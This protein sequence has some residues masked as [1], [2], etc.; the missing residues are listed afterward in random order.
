MDNILMR[1]DKHNAGRLEGMLKEDPLLNGVM[2]GG[3]EIYQTLLSV[4]DTAESVFEKYGPDAAAEYVFN[5]LLES[6]FA[7]KHESVSSAIESNEKYIKG[8]V[9]AAYAGTTIFMAY[10]TAKAAAEQMHSHGADAGASHAP[11]HAQDSLGAGNILDFFLPSAAGMPSNEFIEPYGKVFNATVGSSVS[12][13]ITNATTHE[14]VLNYTSVPVTEDGGFV[15]YNTRIFHGDNPWTSEIENVQPGDDLW[16]FIN[17]T[18]AQLNATK[19]DHWNVSFSDPVMQIDIDYVPPAPKDTTPP[20]IEQ[21]IYH[22]IANGTGVKNRIIVN[23]ATDE[24]TNV[25]V[26]RGG[27]VVH[28]NA[29]YSLEKMFELAANNG[30]NNFSIIAKD[31]SANAAMRWLNVSLDLDPA[32]LSDFSAA[33]FANDADGRK[34]DIGV[35]ANRSKPA[36]YDIYVNGTKAVSN[37]TLSKDAIYEI[38]ANASEGKNDIM[39]EAVT[40]SGV[41][42]S[43]SGT[44]S[45]DTIAPYVLDK[46]VNLLDKDEVS[47]MINVSEPSNWTIRRDGIKIGSNKTKNIGNLFQIIYTDAI[48]SGAGTYGYALDLNDGRNVNDSISLGTITIK[49][50]DKDNG[51]GGGGNNENKGSSSGGGGGGGGGSGEEYANIFNTISG[52]DKEWYLNGTITYL[53]NGSDI[54]NGSAIKKLTIYSKEGRGE[55]SARLQA[56]KH[57]SSMIPA[58]IYRELAEDIGHGGGTIISNLNLV[59]G[60]N[61]DLNDKRVRGAEIEL[62]WDNR[63]TEPIVYAYQPAENRLTKLEVTDNGGKLIAKLPVWKNTTKVTNI[64]IGESPARST[65]LPQEI[66]VPRATDGATPP[67]ADEAKSPKAAAI[68]EIEALAAAGSL[69]AAYAYRRRK[70]LGQK[71]RR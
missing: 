38:L 25:S 15:W 3:T 5:R 43:V 56:L 20:N 4:G 14:E 34:N 54:R 46:S 41:R 8:A 44:V 27:E 12:I 9:E 21:L 60:T 50:K 52:G 24:E 16:Y 62:R 68:P 55:V 6:S 2:R 40:G 66:N 64:V 32:E 13:K 18:L 7:Q 10:L 36:A 17:G 29:T 1:S 63:E 26:L 65:Y 22:A 61:S 42:S 57:N 23:M 53:F 51:G 70:V 69:A 39:I 45:V 31:R 35:R 59:V 30:D 58:E 71:I 48:T 49:K 67:V 11:T 47:F 37:G 19:E 33:L 28:S